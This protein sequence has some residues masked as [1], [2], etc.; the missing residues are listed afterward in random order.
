MIVGIEKFEKDLA[1]AKVKVA[2]GDLRYMDLID[3]LEAQIA[4][5]AMKRIKDMR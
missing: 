1:E 3:L 5:T 2:E 4:E